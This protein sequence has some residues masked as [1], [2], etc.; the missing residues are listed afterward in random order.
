[1]R[2]IDHL[3]P[4]FET[5]QH[6]IHRHNAQLLCLIDTLAQPKDSSLRSY[7]YQPSAGRQ[8]G[9]Q[10]PAGERADIHAGETRPA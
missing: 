9:N 7:F 8:I 3:P 6:P 5:L 2:G 10:Q 4:L 1:M